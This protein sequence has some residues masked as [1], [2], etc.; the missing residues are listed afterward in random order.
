MVALEDIEVTELKGVG[1]KL[2]ETLAKI[3]I[4]N[5]Q[6]LLFHLPFRYEDRTRIHSTASL[7]PGMQGLFEVDVVGTRVAHGKRRS[8]EVSVRDS[9]GQVVLR[10]YH[11]SAAQARQ[12]SAGTYLRCYGEARL[13]KSGIEFY[14]P[15]YSII[16]RGDENKVP[17]TLTPVYPLT[18]GIQQPRLR[19]LCTQALSWLDRH[20]VRDLLPLPLRQEFQLPDIK[21][22]LQYLH[23]PP[24]DADQMAMLEGR[25]LSQKRLIVEELLAH[26]MSLMKLR[27]GIRRHPSLSCPTETALA[28]YMLGRLPFELTGA[29]QRV[30]EEIQGDLAA[31]APMLR[32]VQGDVG[33]GKTIVAAL[34]ALQAIAAGGQV[35]L[36]AP[37]EILAEQHLYNFSQWFDGLVLPN[38]MPIT[39]E[40]LSGKS[41][42]KVRQAALEQIQNGAAHIVV[43]THAL[44]V[45]DVVFGQLSLAI[46]DE[47]HR[48]GVHQ[49]LSLK[50]K[51]LRSGI[52]PHQLIMT[53]T[54]IP[55]TLAMSAYADLDTSVIDEL[56]PG[57]QKIETFAIPDTRRQ[58]MVERVLRAC[59]SGCQA[60]W[61]CTLI[62]ESDA[63]Q[64]QAAEETLAWLQGQLSGLIV[65]L[66]HGRMKAKDK[67]FIMEQFKDGKIDV[68]VATTVIE[69]GVDVPNAS[70]IVIENPE[71]LGLAQLH[72]LRGRVGR[73][74]LKSYCAL[75][76]HSPLS[77]NGKQRLNVMRESNDGF[78]IAEKDLE[79]R[80]PGEVLGTRQTGAIDFKIADLQR[81]Q[82]WLPEI[83]KMAECLA[84]N[85]SL[86]ELLIHRW[87]GSRRQYGEV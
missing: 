9:S 39:L 22:A 78:V 75:M 14:H 15:E 4:H 43:G 84:G 68:L 34:A 8:L 61:V 87:I 36:M 28:G 64:C 30:R 31:N 1:K 25:H 45:E 16:G 51:G 42:G 77:V 32:L 82:D 65:G 76:F 85:E 81:D 48:F 10:F 17:E 47:Q 38:G 70:L 12:L 67:S 6:D 53:A 27:Q 11:F 83:K 46:I 3:D 18:E 41:K 2:A 29:Q 7:R 80:G 55:R 19:A 26:H 86:I 52:V 56:P 72:Q 49:R 50:N 23:R 63:L 54:P 33:S 73:G 57:R 71:R 62:E 58:E 24:A 40:W 66:V 20:E 59:Q 60:Y 37:T 44:F 79:L 69:V 35:A 13:G 74:E 21:H 5:L